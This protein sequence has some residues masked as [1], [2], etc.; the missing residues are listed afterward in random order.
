M[1]PLQQLFAP[2]IN[3]INV[4]DFDLRQTTLYLQILFQFPKKL[5]RLNAVTDATQIDL[6]GENIDTPLNNSFLSRD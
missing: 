3:Y 5:I 1:G 4:R 6:H 2:Y